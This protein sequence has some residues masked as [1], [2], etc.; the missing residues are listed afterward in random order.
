MNK[1]DLEAHVVKLERSLARLREQNKELKL[2]ART[3]PQAVEAPKSKA[4]SAKPA[5]KPV[6]AIPAAKASRSRKPSMRNGLASSTDDT[7]QDQDAA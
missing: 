1:A 2:S 3:P 4:K 6:A 7:G 5:A